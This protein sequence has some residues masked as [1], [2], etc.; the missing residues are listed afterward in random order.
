MSLSL[1]SELGHT[2]ELELDHK[3]GHTSELELDHE[4]GPASDLDHALGLANELELDSTS[5]LK[6]D[7][8]TSEL[9]LDLSTSELELDHEPTSSPPELDHR[10]PQSKL[11]LASLHKWSSYS[12]A[13][14]IWA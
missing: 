7:L 1:T 2:N 11:T 4:L 10:A 14:P 3:L 13:R 5:E 12:L 6:L 9:E 8:S